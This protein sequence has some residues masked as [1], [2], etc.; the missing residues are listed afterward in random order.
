MSDL[1]AFI[2]SQNPNRGGKDCDE[3][4]REHLGLS[5]DIEITQDMKQQYLQE[6]PEMH[7]MW[8]SMTSGQI[9]GSYD[10]LIISP[11]SINNP[12]QVGGA[13][14]NVQNQI[15]VLEQLEDALRVQQR[16]SPSA[17][18]TPSAPEQELPIPT[19]TFER[20]IQQQ[21]HLYGSTNV[22]DQLERLSLEDTDD[23]SD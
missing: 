23:S 11:Q 8:Q 9:Q 17:R 20:Q 2:M 18:P 22:S 12:Q 4:I 16:G 10:P 15:N 6:Y 1:D 7:E 14:G 13:D 21:P 3:L 19:V 5:D